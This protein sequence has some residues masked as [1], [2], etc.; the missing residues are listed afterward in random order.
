MSIKTLA[1]K[2][3]IDSRPISE[4]DVVAILTEE[5]GHEYPETGTVAAKNLWLLRD[6]VNQGG[7]GSIPT[8]PISDEEIDEEIGDI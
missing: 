3:Y 6:W 1:Q 5:E 2:A 4:D 8:I 7:G